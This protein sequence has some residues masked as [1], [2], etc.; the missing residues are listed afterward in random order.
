MAVIGVVV[1]KSLILKEVFANILYRSREDS[2]V[3][4]PFKI[5]AKLYESKELFFLMDITP[6]YPPVYWFGLLVLI[7]FI[8][9]G[10]F[11]WFLL[12]PILLF[13]IGFLWSPYFYLLVLWGAI[14]KNK[15][16]GDVKVLSKDKIIKRLLE[17]DK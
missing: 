4:N 17:W 8:V 10:W 6:V 16:K 11:N 5:N 12:I 7:P 14:R 1:E 9:F 15:Y 3:K 2:L 13:S